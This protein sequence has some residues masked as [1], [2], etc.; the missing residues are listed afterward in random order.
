MQ[1][2]LPDSDFRRSAL[3]L[4]RR[5]LG[6][7]RVEALQV[8]RGLTVP[9]YG[10]RRHPAV[11]MW[12]GYEEALVRYGLEVCRVWREQGHQDSCAASLV[13]GYAGARPGAPVRDQAALSR[14][15]ELPP[16]L[17]DDAFHRSHQ[18][19]LVRKDRELYAG[20]FPGVPDDLPYV[21][22]SSDREADGPS[23]IPSAPPSP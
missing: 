12:S 5:R 4:D 19:A 20:L 9:G 11:R 10:W 7:Q 23:G 14:A 17:G 18:S 2:F 21:W 3:L 22:P 8:L 16:W 6:K 13:A 15:G 1:T